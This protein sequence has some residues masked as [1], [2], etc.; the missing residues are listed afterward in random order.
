MPNNG[1]EEFERSL[2]E[3]PVIKR[4]EYDYFVHPLVDGI[5]LIEPEILNEIGEEI[6]KLASP[7]L[8]RIV[9]VEAMGIPLA[10]VVSLKTGIPFTII[11]KRPY[12]MEDEFVIDQ[13]TGYSK[14]K[15]YI[16]GLKPGMKVILVDDVLSTGGTLRA[17]V[18]GLKKVG[19]DILDIIILVEKSDIRPSLEEELGQKIRVLSK[20]EI[21]DGKVRILDV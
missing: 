6:I 12:G 19:V 14:G 9:T 20:I 21:V 18:N 11:R 2:L 1:L 4:G 10:S 16:N 5:P 8:E 7:D 15:L 3:C 13:S 17:V